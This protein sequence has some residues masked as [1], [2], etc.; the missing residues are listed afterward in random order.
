MRIALV[1]VRGARVRKWHKIAIGDGSEKLAIRKT[2]TSNCYPNLVWEKA[3]PIANLCHPIGLLVGFGS[4]SF[5]FRVGNGIFLWSVGLVL[6]S[7]PFM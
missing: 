1:Q 7:G 6:L 5:V 2:V 4:A 3:S